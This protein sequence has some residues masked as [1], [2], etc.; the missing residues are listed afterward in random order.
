M[1][2]HQTNAVVGVVQKEEMEEKINKRRDVRFGDGSSGGEGGEGQN[3]L[4]GGQGSGVG[5][6]INLFTTPPLIAAD[7]NVADGETR[8][9][10]KGMSSSI[11]IGCS[12]S[13]T[14][15]FV[16]SYWLIPFGH[17]LL[18][19]AFPSKPHP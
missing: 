6:L 4:W 7:R 5:S 13:P 8:R 10:W 2:Q 17:L 18:L 16:S 3:G 14:D 15:G 9:R 11:C 19:P 12:V 1:S